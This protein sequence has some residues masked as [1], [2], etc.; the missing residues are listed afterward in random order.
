MADELL[1]NLTPGE[2]YAILTSPLLAYRVSGNLVTSVP[3]LRRA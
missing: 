2:R 1:S 3:G